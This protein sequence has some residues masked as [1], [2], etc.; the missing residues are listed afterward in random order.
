MDLFNCINHNTDMYRVDGFSDEVIVVFLAQLLEALKT[1]KESNVIHRDIK[2]GEKCRAKKAPCLRAAFVSNTTGLSPSSLRLA[3]LVVALAAENVCVDERGN[4]VLTDFELAINGRRNND[5]TS[6]PTTPEESV[7]VG[8]TLYIAPE[9]YRALEY[10]FKTD[11][12]AVAILTCEL[13]SAKLPWI[14]HEHMSAEEV[15]RV[16]INNRPVKPLGMSNAVWAFLR[17]I[18]VLKDLR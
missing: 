13:H 9:T 5:D 11:L 17:K 12:W 18:L 1:L 14:I 4:L 6:P 8:T 7:L 15:G 2:P 3:L 16:I 10:S